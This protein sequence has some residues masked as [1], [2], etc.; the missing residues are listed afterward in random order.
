MSTKIGMG[1][2][3]IERWGTYLEERSLCIAQVCDSWDLGLGLLHGLALF[4]PF[5]PR[6]FKTLLNNQ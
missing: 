1:K 3:K 6:Q 4:V 2:C 5:D